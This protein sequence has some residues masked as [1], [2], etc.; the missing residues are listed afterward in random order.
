MPFHR[1]ALDDH[2]HV[3]AAVEADVDRARGH[4]LDQTR[5][6]AEGRGLDGQAVLLENA[7]LHSDFEQRVGEGRQRRFADAKRLGLRLSAED[8]DRASDQQAT[9]CPANPCGKRHG[10][11]P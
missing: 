8:Y 5:A 4:A 6:A 3:G 2:G 1:R 11:S 9:K 7:G 10:H